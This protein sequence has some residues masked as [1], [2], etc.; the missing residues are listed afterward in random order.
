MWLLIIWNAFSIELTMAK[1]RLSIVFNIIWILLP[2]RF[3]IV[4]QYFLY[5]CCYISYVKV[6]F[7][8]SINQ[9][10]FGDP[11][12]CFQIYLYW[13]NFLTVNHL[14]NMA[15]IS[16]YSVGGLKKHKSFIV[17]LFVRSNWVSLTK[18]KATMS[19]FTLI[20]FLKPTF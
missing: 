16:V 5:Y 6:W 12:W 18:F 3:K 11:V 8:G 9:V 4:L 14:S 15:N 13:R 7:Y 20:S 2:S 19:N 10:L 17:W 1:F